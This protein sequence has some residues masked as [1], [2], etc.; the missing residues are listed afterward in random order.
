MD[1]IYNGFTFVKALSLNNPTGTIKNQDKED[2]KVE[3]KPF[4]HAVVEFRTVH[5]T[6]NGSFGFDWYRK[7][8]NGQSYG[9]TYKYFIK[10]GYKDG[11]TN[12]KTDEAINRFLDMYE[13]IPINL[14]SRKSQKE[15]ELKNYQVPYLSMFSKETVEAMKLPKDIIQP[16]FSTT[17]CAIVEIVRNS[18]LEFEYD[19]TLFEV[20]PKMLADKSAEKEIRQSK[21]AEITITCKKD[22]DSNKE[23]K[24]YAYPQDKKY[25]RSLAGKIT[26]LQNDE[27]VRKNV[28]FALVNVK[29]KIKEELPFNTG[30]IEPEEINTLRKAMYQCL[31]VP[32]ISEASV[33]DLANNEYFKIK[34]D[35]SG[36]YTYGKY[37]YHKT[38]T[39]VKWTDSG[40]FH[41][42]DY[43]DCQDY[44]KKL[45]ISENQDYLKNTFYKNTKEQV[46]EKYLNENTFTVFAFQEDSFKT[47]RSSSFFD[48]HAIEGE[49]KGIGENT[50]ML[51]N[52]LHS[53]KRQD[54]TSLAHEV[55][56]GLGVY[57]THKDEDPI[58]N[59]KILCT[60]EEKSTDNYM[61][62]RAVDPSGT[63]Q[64]EERE[65]LW[66]W[67]WKIANMNIPGI[68]NDPK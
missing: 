8:D 37:I 46:D 45:Y 3:E 33:L 54:E 48:N 15:R 7:K 57:H 12:L 25:K 52:S 2:N 11:R 61:S 13:E 32:N 49:V 39:T 64:G 40:I 20:T 19:T 10:S 47:Y 36:N 34:K 23:I 17:L 55:L 30:K 65:T 58:P 16:Q 53:T 28:N 35:I 4:S 18:V 43:N 51:F 41:T 6:Y 5:K 60:F 62:Y 50:A 31:I 38:V 63:I 24:I 66:R 59:P 9:I 1:N 44:V 29:T 42:L 14:P 27:K 26:V 22:L 56:H 67:Q 21:T 68:E